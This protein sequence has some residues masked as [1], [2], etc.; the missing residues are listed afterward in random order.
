VVIVNASGGGLTAEIDLAAP[1]KDG[2]A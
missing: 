2:S 1:P